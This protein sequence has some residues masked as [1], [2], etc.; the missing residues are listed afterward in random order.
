M[1]MGQLEEELYSSYSSAAMREEDLPPFADLIGL[2]KLLF[3]FFP[4]LKKKKKTIGFPIEKKTQFTFP[5]SPIIKSF[6]K[7]KGK[8]LLETNLSFSWGHNYSHQFDS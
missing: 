3:F 7:Q 5:W 2:H 6:K 4:V 8:Y 1:L